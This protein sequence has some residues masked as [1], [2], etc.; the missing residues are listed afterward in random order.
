[1]HEHLN[2]ILKL[3]VTEKEIHAFVKSL[4]NTHGIVTGGDG[5][6]DYRLP[7]IHETWRKKWGGR[8]HIDMGCK[9]YHLMLDKFSAPLFIDF[10]KSYRDENSPVPVP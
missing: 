2:D 4:R 1:M 3:S 8:T 6:I 10:I 7:F 9:C 5:R